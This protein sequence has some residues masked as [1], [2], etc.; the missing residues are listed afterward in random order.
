[1]V[2]AS[3]RIINKYIKGIIE[4]IKNKDSVFMYGLVNKCIK[5]NLRMILGKDMV[6]LL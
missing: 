1:M 4:W 5:V 6:N 2:M 3:G